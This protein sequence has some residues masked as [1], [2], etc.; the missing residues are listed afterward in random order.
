MEKSIMDL[1]HDL[2]NKVQL[3]TLVLGLRKEYP[4]VTYEKMLAEINDLAKKIRENSRIAQCPSY[5]LCS[6]SN[7]FSELENILKNISPFHPGVKIEISRKGF[8]DSSAPSLLF[9]PELIHQILENAIHNS[10]KA[11]ADFISIKIFPEGHKL[12]LIIED[13]G[14]GFKDMGVSEFSPIGFGCRIMM[15]NTARLLG[16]I[17]FANRH[18]RGAR[19]KINLPI[20]FEQDSQLPFAI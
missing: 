5:Y 19:I 17:S 18:A 6:L 3:L 8:T 13:N 12:T 9:S 14:T 10:N 2:S 15:N 4:K 11:E 20:Q 7:F 16:T 1:F